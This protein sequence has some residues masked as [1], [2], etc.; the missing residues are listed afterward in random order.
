MAKL[1]DHDVFIDSIRLG[2]KDHLLRLI[3]I[4]AGEPIPYIKID[5]PTDVIKLCGVE[6]KA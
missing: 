4:M 3:S 2:N 6:I 1:A 5:N